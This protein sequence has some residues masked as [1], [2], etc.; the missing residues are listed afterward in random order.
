VITAKTDPR[1]TVTLEDD[2]PIGE[3]F[4]EPEII[5]S[6]RIVCRECGGFGCEEC[7]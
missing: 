5:V 1:K 4:E 7:R 2:L 6:G 3:V